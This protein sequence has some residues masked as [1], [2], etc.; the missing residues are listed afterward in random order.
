VSPRPS[1]W[2]WAAAGVWPV[3]SG[4][5]LYGSQITVPDVTGQTPAA[6]QTQLE[7]LGL[8]VTVDPT[9]IDGTQPAGQVAATNP[10]AGSS[11]SSGGQVTIQVSNG[12]SATVPSGLVGQSVDQAKAA[13]AAAGFTNVTVSSGGG[14]GG[15][16]GGAAG[17]ATVTSVQPGEGSPA[18][19]D[20]A[21][22]LSTG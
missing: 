22:V 13:L 2:V 18:R 1:S 5:V 16:S 12:M 8:T 21:I 20:A 14:G 11:I 4:T 3:T 10:S 9:P 15:G 7:G 17:S 19:K 6:A